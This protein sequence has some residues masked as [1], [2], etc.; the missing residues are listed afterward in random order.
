MSKL[1]CT[2]DASQ[3]IFPLN[4]WKLLYIQGAYICVLEVTD[5]T[6]L[7]GGQ[8]ICPLLRGGRGE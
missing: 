5:Q 4:W 6:N 1:I 2:Y 3:E 7:F 8:V